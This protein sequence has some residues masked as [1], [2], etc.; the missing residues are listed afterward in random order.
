M[1]LHQLYHSMNIFFEFSNFLTS[2]K[3]KFLISQ[4]LESGV[5]DEETSI[6]SHSFYT[7]HSWAGAFTILAFI[8]QVD[9]VNSLPKQ[10][11]YADSE[12]FLG[13]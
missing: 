10:P 3:N 4:V 7:F 5:S 6:S 9:T 13:L 12:G 11:I 2:P 8:A 1:S